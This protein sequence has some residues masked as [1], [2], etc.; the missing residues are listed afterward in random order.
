MTIISISLYE[1][2]QA[3]GVEEKPKKELDLKEYI[4]SEYHEFLPLFSE[5]LGTNLPPHISKKS[6]TAPGAP[7]APVSIANSHKRRSYILLLLGFGKKKV[8]YF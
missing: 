2:N 7:V 1:I 4:P 5:A 8:V 3:L 6:K